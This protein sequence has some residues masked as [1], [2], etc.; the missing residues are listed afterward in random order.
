LL[1]IA[2]SLKLGMVGASEFILRSEG[3]QMKAEDVAHLST[4]L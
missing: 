2:G 1:R 3:A 4:A